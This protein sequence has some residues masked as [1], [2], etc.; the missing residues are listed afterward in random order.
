[1]TEGQRNRGEKG[2]RGLGPQQSRERAETNG[3]GEGVDSAALPSALERMSEISDRCRDKRIAAFLDYDGTLTPIVQRPE[4]AVMAEDMRDVVARLAKRQTVAVI[5]GRDLDDV[6]DLIKV[7]GI[8]YAG[9]HG[10]DIADPDGRRIEIDR[11]A[12]SL[13]ELDRAEKRLHELLDDYEGVQIERKR[14]SIAVH[15][16]RA[17]EKDVGSVDG[18]LDEVNGESKGLRRS[19]GKKVFELQPDV[20]WNKGEALLFLLDELGLGG[21]EVVPFY[22]GD[23]ITDENAFAV[24]RDRGIG[25]VVRDEPRR[26]LA[27]YALDDVSQVGKFLEELISINDGE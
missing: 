3:E 8:Y 13:G 24:L 2:E 25:I 18:V 5:S 16:R 6:R 9:S 22:L 14:Y 7:D 17:D 10:F 26:S 12:Q 21:R 27:A 15:Y 19:Y 20:P 11:A 1:M 23:D 4:D